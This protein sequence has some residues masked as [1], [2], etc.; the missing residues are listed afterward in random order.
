M[1]LSYVLALLM[2][3]TNSFSINSAAASAELDLHVPAHYM[4]VYDTIT[5]ICCAMHM[6]SGC[7]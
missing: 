6:L 7:N 2:V 5:K 3:R 1:Y 4:Y